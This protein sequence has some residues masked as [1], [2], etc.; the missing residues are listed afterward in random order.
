M[1]FY[2]ALA[3]NQNKPYVAVQILQTMEPHFVCEQIKLLALANLGYVNEVN[4][5]LLS[6]M[7]NERLLKHKISKDVVRSEIVD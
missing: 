6:W 7:T 1:A 3:L 4:E 5:F 2:A